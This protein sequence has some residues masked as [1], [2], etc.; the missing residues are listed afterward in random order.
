MPLSPDPSLTIPTSSDFLPQ[1]GPDVST[2]NA[3][4][5]PNGPS[6]KS[7]GADLQAKA[8][9]NTS[10]DDNGMESQMSPM[11]TAIT[12]QVFGTNSS[13]AYGL[14]LRTRFVFNTNI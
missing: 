7:Q 5:S 14:L 4:T 12:L 3:T 1:P 9:D 8:N 11:T 10:E 6:Q 13:T 2:T